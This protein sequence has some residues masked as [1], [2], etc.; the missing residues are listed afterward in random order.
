[1][2]PRF[3][4]YATAHAAWHLP[5]GLVGPPARWAA[6]SNVE[7]G[8]GTE[9]WA[10]GLLARNRERGLLL[11]KLFARAHE[12]LVTLLPMGPVC[13]MSQGRFEEAVRP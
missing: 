4:S 8:S 1:M 3:P 7:A 5:G 12:I 9:V 13:L 11:D 6:T 10:Q 2:G